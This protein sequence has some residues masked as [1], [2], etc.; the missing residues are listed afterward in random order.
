MDLGVYIPAKDDD[1]FIADVI[2]PVLEVFPEVQFIDLGSVDKTV[3]IAKSM[4]L[5]VHVHEGLD[6]LAYKKLLN[7]Y[8]RMHDWVVWID[9]DE[10]FPVECLHRLKELIQIGETGPYKTVRCSWK[11]IKQE[12]DGLYVDKKL[13]MNGHEAFDCKEFNFSNPW[14]YQVLAGDLSK[15]EPKIFNGVWCWHAVLMQRSSVRED[16]IRRK[17]RL[18]KTEIYNRE[19]EWE[20]VDKLPWIL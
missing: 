1:I 15:R 19:L 16:N 3:Q 9:S 8:S 14:P 4:G 6:G 10:I 20:K 5:P 11:M 7:H 13:R 17:K 2:K 18:E 12:E